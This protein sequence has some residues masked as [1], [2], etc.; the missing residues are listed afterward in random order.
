MDFLVGLIILFNLFWDYFWGYSWAQIFSAAD[1]SCVWIFQIM[2]IVMSLHVAV[3][4]HGA[5]GKHWSMETEVRKQKYGS[6]KESRLSVSSALL[7]HD[8]A[9]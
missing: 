7:T 8:C 2:Y 6:E 1:F 5:S 9:L 3:S 4:L